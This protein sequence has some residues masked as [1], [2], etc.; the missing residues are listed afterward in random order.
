MTQELRRELAT[1]AR[2]VPIPGIRRD[3]RAEPIRIRSL[4]ASLRRCRGGTWS[5]RSAM[6]TGRGARGWS[7]PLW[8][9]VRAFVDEAERRESSGVPLQLDLADTFRAW[10]SVRPSSGARACTRRSWS[11]LTASLLRSRNHHHVCWRK[12]KRCV[13]CSRSYWA[14]SI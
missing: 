1:V 3:K 11:W 12:P 5:T 2:F 9:A 7:R 4:S 8:R 13:R 14:A 10:C 6:R